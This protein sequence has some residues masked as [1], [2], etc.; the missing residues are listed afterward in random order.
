[1]YVL[2]E[3]DINISWVRGLGNSLNIPLLSMD[4]TGYWFSNRIL[5]RTFLCLKY[6]TA[7]L[8]VHQL[9]KHNYFILQDLRNKLIFNIEHYLWWWKKWIISLNKLN[10]L[11]LTMFST[12]FLEHWALLKCYKNNVSITGLWVSLKY[13]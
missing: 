3:D 11:D 2:V 13:L 8:T 7:Q 9:F 4:Y 1:M 10:I 12:A 5:G 6:I